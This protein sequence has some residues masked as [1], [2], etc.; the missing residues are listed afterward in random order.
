MRLRPKAIGD[1]RFQLSF[2]RNMCNF[3]TAIVMLFMIGMAYTHAQT[4][5]VDP[6]SIVA[7]PDK[8]GMETPSPDC[9][10]LGRPHIQG[11]Q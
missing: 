4:A 8:F 7:L 1:A 11:Q 9:T 2:G 3:V 10:A 6:E 5:T